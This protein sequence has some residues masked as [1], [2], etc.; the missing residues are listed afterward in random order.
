MALSLHTLIH[1][2][3]AQQNPT[4]NILQATIQMATS[5][6]LHGILLVLLAMLLQNNPDLFTRAQRQEGDNVVSR[7]KR[8]WRGVTY[9]GTKWCGPGNDAE[10]YDE[11]GRLNKTDACC[12]EH[13]HCDT[14]I[15]RFRKRFHYFNW[16][17]FTISLC[18]CD[19]K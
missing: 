2:Y 9:T 15:K 12:R 8:F 18:E 7:M 5:R 13:D 3:P 17:A 11:L 6:I 19:E 16:R 4:S 10:D 1:T 14:K